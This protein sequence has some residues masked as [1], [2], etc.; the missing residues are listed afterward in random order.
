MRTFWM[1]VG[2]AAVG[3]GLGLLF[4]PAGSNTRRMIK[5]KT[6]KCTEDTQDLVM[7]NARRLRTKAR[8]YQHK[9]GELIAQSKELAETGKGAMES[10]HEVI[11]QGHELVEQSREVI[12]KVKLASQ[13]SGQATVEV[14]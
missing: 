9:A 4:S 13:T 6:A 10:V 2:G 1:A 7:R 3:A 5:D 14:A 11:A 12:Q 8:G